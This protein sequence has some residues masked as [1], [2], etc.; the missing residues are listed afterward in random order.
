MAIR[1]IPPFPFEIGETYK[2]K[3]SPKGKMEDVEILGFE[4]F[5]EDNKMKVLLTTVR[6]GASQNNKRI[7]AT[8]YLTE[9]GEWRS[10]LY[11]EDG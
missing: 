3:T 4:S 8:F 7:V 9:W 1:T 2:T 11:A 6:S 5:P 10:D